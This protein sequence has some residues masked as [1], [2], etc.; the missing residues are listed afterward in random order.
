M[1]AY[2]LGITGGIASGKTTVMRM[3]ARHGIPGIS[4]DDLAHQCIRRG[5]PAYRAILARFGRGILGQAGQID[6][7]KLGK[8][9]FSEPAK[10]QVLERIVHPCVIRG[11]RHFIRGHD[12][13][14][15]LDIPLLFEAHLTRLVNR[16]VVVYCTRKQQIL[17]LMKR[18]HCSR[19]AALVRLRAQMP[20]SGKRGKAD[21]RIDNTRGTSMLKA[22]VRLLLKSLQ[23]K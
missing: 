14:I 13:L 6:R 9:V 5:Q 10:R 2:V 19:T 23:T 1:R 17:R 20:L 8:I 11:L 18:D 15:A 16:S 21:V 12:G 7:K 22:Q 4:S 3:L